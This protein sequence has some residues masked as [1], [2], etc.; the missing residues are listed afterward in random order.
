MLMFDLRSAARTLAR[1]PGFT[2][3]ATA[4]LALGIGAN[5]VIFGA[6]DAILL[7]PLPVRE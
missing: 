2:L 4:L 6:L 1:S 5:A 7:R 3:L